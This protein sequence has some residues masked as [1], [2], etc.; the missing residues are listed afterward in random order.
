[1]LNHC[2]QPSTIRLSISNEVFIEKYNLTVIDDKNLC[3]YLNEERLSLTQQTFPLIIDLRDVLHIKKNIRPILLSSTFRSKCS[4]IGLLC[5]NVNS[6]LLADTLIEFH[7]CS[8][9]AKC[10]TDILSA[11]EWLKTSK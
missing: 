10:F 5:Q 9:P 2:V 3:I 8:I 1:M 4:R 6:R 11:I 7:S